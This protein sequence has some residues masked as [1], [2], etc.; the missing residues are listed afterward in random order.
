M[1]RIR[2]FFTG[3]LEP[4]RDH[5]LALD[6]WANYFNYLNN[7]YGFVPAQTL[8]GERMEAPGDF[9]G[10]V[11]QIYKESGPIFSCELIRTAVFSEARFMFRERPEGRPGRLY[12]GTQLGLL[13]TPWPGGTTG[14]LLARM[15]QDADFQGDA[16][17]VRRLRRLKRLR[18]DWVTVVYG[19]SGRG[20]MWDL[21][22]ELL[23]YLYHPGGPNSENDPEALLPEEVAHFAPIPDPLSPGRGMPWITPILREVMGDVAATT[24]KL[25]FFEN[26]ATPN[27][28]VT[29]DIT[30]PKKFESWIEIFDQRHQGVSNAYKTL[31]LG[32]A[33][34]ATPVGMSFEQMDFKVVQ[35]AGE[36]RIAAAAG[37][38]PV[39][40]GFSE[41][42]ES[43][44]YSNYSQARRRF[45]DGT[46][47]P[48]WRNCAG[49]L[50]RIVN[51]PWGS[52]LWYDES[53]V[54]F[55]R[56]DQKDEAEI[57]QIQTQ[58]IRS[59]V[60]AGFE[61]DAAIDAVTAGDLTRLT[62]RHTGL[63][64]VQLQPPGSSE[65]GPEPEPEPEDNGSD[66]GRALAALKSLTASRR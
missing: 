65:P 38:P 22:A 34:K 55:L 49:S 15:I 52:E 32:A 26:A 13:N 6:E 33:A 23:G 62:G 50:A 47:R 14:D 11:S 9:S 12:G 18:P 64:S 24:H 35:G 43:A 16:F 30:D 2:D 58:A 20:D 63:F 59:L 36:T 25:R 1:G 5:P 44:T 21:D 48:L 31:Y 45:A 28:A 53:D 41:G 51:V 61:A 57:Q 37:V 8:Q 56:E 19:T 27:L 3:G 66:Q 10:Y 7:S 46:L 39:I 60:D 17:V 54:A 40:A 42:L 29:L 4:T